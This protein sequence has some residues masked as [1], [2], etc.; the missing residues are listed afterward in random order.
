M[1]LL[2]TM[3]VMMQLSWSMLLLSAPFT[4]F[5]LWQYWSVNSGDFGI[6]DPTKIIVRDKMRDA[7]K[8]SLGY[9]GFHLLSFFVFMWQLISLLSPD[10]TGTKP[11]IQGEVPW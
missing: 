1:L 11:S 6:Y 3:L 5:L 9:M 10:S 7:I 2:H 8:Q 4:G